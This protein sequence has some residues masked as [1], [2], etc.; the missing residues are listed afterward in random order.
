MHALRVPGVQICENS[1]GWRVVAGGLEERERGERR[2]ERGRGGDWG[3][4]YKA[5]HADGAWRHHTKH[6]GEGA[7][8]H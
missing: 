1:G 4:T 2:G 5:T 6:A 7:I 8:H 3:A